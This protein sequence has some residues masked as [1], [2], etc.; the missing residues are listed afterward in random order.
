MF[1]YPDPQWVAQCPPC[2]FGPIA[3]L[4]RDQCCSSSS[5]SS[6]RSHSHSSSNSNN[7]NINSNS[8]ISR[9]FK[10][11]SISFIKKK[12]RCFRVIFAIGLF[13]NLFF[14]FVPPGPGEIPMGM[15]VS[16]YGPAAPSN[17]LGSWPDTMLS[18]EQGPHGT[19]NRWGLIM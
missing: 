18:M 4:V 11:V 16:P 6:S 19:Q 7:S 15:G 9:C 3:F 17:Q 2:L 12:I 10:C 1:L 14:L 5:N 8:N 13:E